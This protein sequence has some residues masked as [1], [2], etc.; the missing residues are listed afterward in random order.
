MNSRYII[1][2]FF[3]QILQKMPHNLAHLWAFWGEVGI[4]PSSVTYGVCIKSKIYKLII[5]ILE[6]SDIGVMA[7]YYDILLGHVA[8]LNFLVDSQVFSGYF[9]AIKS[10]YSGRISLNIVPNGTNFIFRFFRLLAICINEVVFFSL[11]SFGHVT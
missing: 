10:L 5:I 1:T 8:I 11:A 7:P 2:G 4:S 9:R 6:E 3:S